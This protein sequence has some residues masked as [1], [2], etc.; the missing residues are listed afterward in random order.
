MKKIL[1]SLIASLMLII[2]NVNMYANATVNEPES[3]R[4]ILIIF[5]LVVIVVIIIVLTRRMT[6]K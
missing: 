4:M 1:M 2:N 6:N 5:L 3:N